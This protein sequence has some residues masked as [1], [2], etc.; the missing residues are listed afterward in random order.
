[1]LIQFLNLIDQA[2]FNELGIKHQ[3]EIEIK[4]YRTFQS[5]VFGNEQKLKI[6]PEVDM[7]NYA[8][9][10]L[11]TGS[12]SDKRELLAC[13]KSKLILKDKRLELE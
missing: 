2:D 3:L 9:Y 13:L 10:I 11:Q 6:N 5:S 12:T 1:M 7:K 8:K 4:R